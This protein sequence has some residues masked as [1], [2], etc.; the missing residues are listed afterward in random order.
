MKLEAWIFSIVTVFF[1][2]VTPAYW[3]ITREPT[4]TTALVL[5]FSLALMISGYLTLVSRRIDPRPEDRPDSEIVEGAGEVGFFPPQSIWPLFCGLTLA[6]A[7]VGLVIG[8]WL[9]IIAMALGTVALTGLIYE[10][11]RG[12]YAH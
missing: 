6:V 10:Y 4:G 1:L 7:M 2:I 9:F 8:W 5:T 11:Y 12:D 3:L